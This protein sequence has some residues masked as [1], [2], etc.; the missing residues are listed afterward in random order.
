MGGLTSKFESYEEN[1]DSNS[2]NFEMLASN[3][4]FAHVMDQIFSYLSAP[5]LCNLRLT[6]KILHCAVEL[7]KRWW[8][9][10]LKFI[11]ST[12]IPIKTI[13]NED[14][15]STFE[16]LWHALKSL[17]EHFQRKES[18]ERVKKYV[19]LLWIYLKDEMDS[20]YWTPPYTKNIEFAN[21]FMTTPFDWNIKH[22]DGYFPLH[23]A[24]RY[25][26][27]DVVKLLLNFLESKNIDFFTMTNFRED[28]FFFAAGNNTTDQI[29]K[30]LLQQFRSKFTNEKRGNNGYRIIH[31]AIRFGH[32]ETVKFLLHFFN[33]F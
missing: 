19:N 4:G 8:L 32:P 28:I 26:N 18:A 2:T 21:F 6:S 29:L 13:F 11:M 7:N 15:E 33:V 3:P 17:N 14:H 27:L 5:D 23:Y 30:F 12:P 25:G 31:W 22:E 1:V 24:C 9:F 16:E 20:E 10:Q